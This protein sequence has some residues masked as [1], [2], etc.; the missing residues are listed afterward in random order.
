MII[1]KIN[2]IT[3]IKMTLLKAVFIYLARI[4][5]KTIFFIL[6]TDLYQTN[7]KIQIKTTFNDNNLNQNKSTLFYLSKAYN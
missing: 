2:I 4:I 6:F 3:Q 1:M 7:Y 5:A